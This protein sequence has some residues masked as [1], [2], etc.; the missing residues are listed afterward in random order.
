MI[1]SIARRA[2]LAGALGLATLLTASCGGDE[3]DNPNRIVFAVLPAE[4]QASSEPLWAPLIDDLRAETG[5]DVEIHFVANYTIL[6][7]AMRANQ[8]Q[9]AWMSAQP[10]LDAVERANGQV[11]GRIMNTE[12]G[13]T[14]HSVVITRRGSGIT[15]QDVMACGRRYSFGMGDARSTSGTLAPMAFLFGPAGIE[16][17]ECFSEVRNANHQANALAVANGVIDVATNNDVGL[18]FTT[19]QNPRA[20]QNIEVI[21]ESPAIPESAIVARR[22]VDPATVERIRS[23]FLTY[24]QGDTPR[25]AE[26]RQVLEGLEY[27]GFQAA[28]ESYL[29]PIRE[30]NASVALMEA[31]RGGDAAAIARAQATYDQIHARVQAAQEI[32]P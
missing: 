5:L 6:V 1:G 17:A 20:A 26:Q 29:D 32:Q 24:G 25:A 19:R 21:W 10:A 7:E 14:Y 4:S 28:D 11:I 15:L 23:F 8:V 12:G 22:D 2:L 16:P 30:M 9:V 18:L 3:A 13:T 31:R 27:G